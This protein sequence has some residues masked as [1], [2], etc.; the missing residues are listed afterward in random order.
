M[1]GDKK[2][3]QEQCDDLR[4]IRQ[5]LEEE[6]QDAQEVQNDLSLQNDI[7][8]KRIE[9]MENRIEVMEKS[10]SWRIGRTITAPGRKL[11]NMIKGN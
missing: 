7:L 1:K 3:L 2:W 9:V 10:S 8:R 5:H 11:K 6:L 4:R